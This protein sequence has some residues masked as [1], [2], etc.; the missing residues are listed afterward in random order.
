MVISGVISPLI[1]TY[2]PAYI[3][4]V[5]SRY[6]P[7]NLDALVLSL[8]LQPQTWIRVKAGSVN[9]DP[10]YWQTVRFL[11]PTSQAGRFRP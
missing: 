9:N 11:R 10:G 4:P 6:L 5:T 8:K 1:Y 7:L 2:N 3:Y